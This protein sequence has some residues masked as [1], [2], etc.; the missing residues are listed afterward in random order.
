MVFFPQASPSTPC[1]HFYPPPYVP[2]VGLHLWNDIKNE[3]QVF[4]ENSV[5]VSMSTTNPT[6]AGLKW[7]LGLR[8][9]WPFRL[10]FIFHS[11]PIRNFSGELALSQSLYI[12]DFDSGITANLTTPFVLPNSIINDSLYTITNTTIQFIVKNIQFYTTSVHLSA[13]RPSPAK[14]FTSTYKVNNNDERGLCFTSIVV[15]CTA[16]E[17]VPKFCV[18]HTIFTYFPSL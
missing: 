4:G 15:L 10:H 9:V 17:D 11:F 14:Y 16:L 12:T 6:M 2:H 5:S 13:T 7:K 1:A 18:Y 3:T 8:C